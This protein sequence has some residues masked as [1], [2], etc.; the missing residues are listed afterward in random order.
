MR[1]DHAEVDP[2]IHALRQFIGTSVERR[3]MVADTIGANE[4]TLYQILRGIP[5]KSGKPRGIGRQ[6]REALDAHF[7]GWRGTPS[8]ASEP[9]VAYSTAPAPTPAARLEADLQRVLAE[10][11]AL[12]PGRWAMVRAR[13]DSVVGAPD[14]VAAAAQDIAALLG[15][16]APGHAPTRTGT[17]G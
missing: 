13:L 14:Q 2:D 10:L 4:Q 17:D 11:A 6:L 8:Q 5:L 7:P 12:S 9:G 3:I 1:L 16:A 15:A